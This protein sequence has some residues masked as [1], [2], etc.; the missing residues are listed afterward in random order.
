MERIL[1]SELAAYA[2][3]RVLLQG[4]LHRTRRL[5]RVSF[6]VL[7]DRAGLAQP[8]CTISRLILD[9]RIPPGVEQEYVFGS[10][11]I[12]SQAACSQADQKKA[13]TIV[14]LKSL[15]TRL[16]VTCP[17]IQ[18]FVDEFFLIQALS[19]NIEKTRELRKDERLV[20][21]FD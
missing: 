17:A 7:R 8:M 3:E 10:C 11:E 6:L 21:P 15:D 13:A 18:I 2:G 20:S 19:H 5:S 1:T 14:F 4:W 16:A 9:G 12:Q